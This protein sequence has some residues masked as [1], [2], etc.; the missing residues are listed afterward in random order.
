[1]PA[2]APEDWQAYPPGVS[3]PRYI[4]N[5]V[6]LNVLWGFLISVGV[7]VPTFGIGLLLV[8]IV[9]PIVFG[10]LIGRARDARKRSQAM[11]MMLG[12]LLV[13]VM[14]LGWCL[15]LLTLRG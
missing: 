11:G 5:V 13:P 6:W 12:M 3:E 10:I 7:A 8:L 4:R 15:G 1:M 2:L 14:L 9:A